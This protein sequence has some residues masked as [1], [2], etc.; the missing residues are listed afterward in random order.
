MTRMNLSQ[1]LC[2]DAVAETGSFQAAAD[3]VARTQQAVFAAVKNLEGQLGLALLDRS[4]YRIGVTEQGRL[5]QRQLRGVL[6]EL[7]ELE[8]LADEL[9]AGSEAVFRVV[10]GDLCPLGP[11]ADFLGFLAPLWQQSELQIRTATLSAPW[12][13][14][15]SQQAELVLHHADQSDPAFEYVPM[16]SVLV[17]PVAAPS[18]C[19]RLDPALP[20]STGLR[21]QMQCVL[22]DEAASPRRD[23]YLQEG[24][25]RNIVDDQH[26]KLELIRCGLAW[27]HMPWHLISG[28]L[29]AGR[30]VDLRSAQLRGGRVEL[31]AARRVQS[32]HGP[33]AEQ[34]WAALRARAEISPGWAGAEER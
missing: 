28:D 29:D 30:L 23:Y 27:G 9:A 3:R 11:V 26:V 1:L 34:V 24:A 20:A 22:R 10:V 14:L 7:G 19:A 13:R 25:R 21:S 17:I 4:G 15:G 32:S 12:E 16:G 2:F 6:R 33:V 8:D 31:V 18:L 5:F